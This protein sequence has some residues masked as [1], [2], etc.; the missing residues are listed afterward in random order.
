MSEDERHIIGPLENQELSQY[1]PDTATSTVARAQLPFFKRPST[2]ISIG[3]IALIPIAAWAISN[4]LQLRG[5]VNVLGSRLFLGVAVVAILLWIAIVTL[6]LAK[7][8]VPFFLCTTV[9]T[10]AAAITAD[11]ITLPRSK[12]L[13]VST[14]IGPS[15]SAPQKQ[16]A[17]QRQAVP[18]SKSQQ[19]QTPRPRTPCSLKGGTYYANARDIPGGENLGRPAFELENAR[20]Y[21]V[22]YSQGDKD[23]MLIEVAITSRGED[24]IVKDWELCLEEDKKAS[25]YQPSDLPSKVITILTGEKISSDMLLTETAVKNPITHGHRV[26]GWVAFTLPKETAQECHKKMPSGSIR[27]KD[28]LAHTYSWDFSPFSYTGNGDVYVPGEKSP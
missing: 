23:W 27:F 2:R 19:A 24:S 16:Q 6:N 21:F 28:Y 20:P 3:G 26:V 25:L 7:R 4:F 9:L 17:Q 15:P 13:P 1:S 22:W 5:F 18:T 8:R 12:A 11:Q 14:L 10:L